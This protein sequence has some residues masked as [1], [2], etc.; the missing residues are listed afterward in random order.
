VK[1]RGLPSPDKA[2]ALALTFAERV[3]PRDMR[4]RDFGAD[5]LGASPLGRRLMGRR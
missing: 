3:V 4:S 2:D 5:I 1:K